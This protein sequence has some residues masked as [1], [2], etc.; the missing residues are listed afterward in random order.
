MSRRTLALASAVT[1]IAALTAAPAEA[2]GH[3]L[4]V[5]AAAPFRPVT[6]AAAGGLYALAEN[7]RPADSTCCP[8]S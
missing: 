7:N 8:S 1:V 4:V 2:A 6:H 5:N 3:T